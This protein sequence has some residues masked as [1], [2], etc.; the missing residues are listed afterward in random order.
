MSYGWFIL[1][2]ASTEFLVLGWL[3]RVKGVSLTGLARALQKQTRR[4]PFVAVL[5][6]VC[7]ACI[8]SHTVKEG[9]DNHFA[10]S[11]EAC[12]ELASGQAQAFAAALDA[13]E[14]L[15]L[16]S[17]LSDVVIAPLTDEQR[18]WLLYFAD[19]TPGPESWGLTGYYGKTSVTVSEPQA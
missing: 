11:L 6:L 18:P 2:L 13:R 3:Q 16:D 9:Q 14:A 4:L 17:S 5:L 8:G 10:T 1:G 12:Y 19:L 15:L 7:M